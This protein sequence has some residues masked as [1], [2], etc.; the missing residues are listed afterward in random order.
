MAA[1]VESRAQLAASRR[2]V[3]AASPIP[4]AAAGPALAPRAAATRRAMQDRRPPAQTAARLRAQEAARARE[5][6]KVLE[7]PIR[8]P[9][10]PAR[11]TTAAVA[12]A[13]QRI[14]QA[15]LSPAH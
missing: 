6:V 13:C 1:P 7:F 5:A 3:R 12:A 15:A 2:P 10:R 4:A 14:P 11:V 9:E 8:R